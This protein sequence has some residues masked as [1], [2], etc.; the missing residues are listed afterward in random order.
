M[1]YTTDCKMKKQI[2]SL[3]ITL[4]GLTIMQSNAQQLTINIR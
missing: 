1:K 4:L 2:L 3:L